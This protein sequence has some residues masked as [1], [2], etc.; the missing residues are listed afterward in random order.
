[1]KEE[2]KKALLELRKEKKR[3]FNQSVD[4]IINLKK[5]DVKKNSIN[6]FIKLPYKIKEKKIGAFLEVKNKNIE[7]ITSE[8]FK[9][10]SDKKRLKKLVKDFDFFLA[11]A[12]LMPKV[13][14]TFGRVLGSAGKMPSPQLGIILETDDET[15]S[16][17][18]EKIN[19]S[20]KI[21]TKEPSIK[22]MAGK[23]DMKE[24]EIIENIITIYEAVEK[25][26]PQ[27]KLNIKNIEVK[28]SMT[29]PIKIE[30]KWN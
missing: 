20:I 16:Q 14:T 12:K 23:E 27:G 18:K 28:F 25:K 1:M 7:T 6:T 24:E 13:A 5:F 29:K 19:S 17:L 15:I 8:E 26:L 9:R 3:N 4:L 11:E 2:L 10:Y 30:V 21:K 22:I